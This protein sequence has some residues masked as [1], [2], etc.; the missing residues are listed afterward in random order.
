MEK[1]FIK[2][3]KADF[4]LIAEQFHIST[5]LARLIVNRGIMSNQ[6]LEEYLNP[7]VDKLHDPY[8]L[9]GMHEAVTILS[10]KIAQGSLI[11]IVGDYD[12]DGIISTYILI[13]ALV[14]C[15]ANVDYEIPDRIKDGYGI[16]SS[17]VEAAY[18]DQVDMLLTCDNGIAATE[19]VAYAKS[20]GMTVVIT[21]HHDIPFNMEG[22]VRN[23]VIPEADVILNPKQQACTYPFKDICGAAVAYK[24]MDALYKKNN[25]TD[26]ESKKM[27][28][29]VAI[30]TVC[31]VM[32][33]VNENRIIVKTGLEY[34]KAT[35]NLGL[36][37]L[38]HANQLEE[39]QITTYHLGYIIGPCMNA[40]GRLESAKIGL[41]L[42]L[43]ETAEEA[44]ALAWELKNLN[45]E[46]KQLTNVGVM[47]AIEQIEEG[48]AGQDRIVVIYLEESHE[49]IAGIIA[50]RIKELYYKPTI[51]LTKGQQGAKG[52]ARSI[53]AYNMYEGLTECSD[54]LTKFGGHPMAAGMSLEI[55]NIP[56]LRDALNKNC[57]LTDEDFIK[58][59]SFDMVLSFEQI[60]IPLI[61]E[62]AALEPH[63]KGNAKPTF[64]VKNIRII[65][66]MKLG[67]N[68]NVL[69]LI[70]SPEGEEKRY[71]AM[72]FSNL[73]DFEEQMI[74]TYGEKQL[75]NMYEGL[76][77]IIICDF[78]FYPDINV[79]QG[80]QNIQFVIQ[81]YRFQ[82]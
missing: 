82:G 39:K 60:T 7:T 46:R 74:H 70:V 47:N 16:N 75:Y 36:K 51:V 25:I 14:R 76:D 41:R 69:K 61:Q 10:Q 31:D 34:I 53:E 65:K 73:I 48:R 54:L 27:L 2:N 35:N 38:I 20:L 11:R 1:W 49:S 24:L 78:I 71:T 19:A 5:V 58:K 42:L 80:Y 77:N 6:E 64:A 3:R 32:D 18:K 72:L 44:Q 59:V 56:K 52:S 63:G 40:S 50:G 13:K 26:V 45:E 15:G 21:D 68:Q 66:G 23:E 4:T 30:A 33:L 67:K 8:L 62:F 43:S 28:E 17:I 12:V 37:A 55:D 81:N 79:Y 29:F 57:R 9:K 22:N